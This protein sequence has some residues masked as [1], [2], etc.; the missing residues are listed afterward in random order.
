MSKEDDRMKESDGCSTVQNYMNGML[1]I[2]S[3]PYDLY[4]SIAA[5]DLN[6]Q[7]GKYLHKTKHSFLSTYIILVLLENSVHKKYFLLKLGSIML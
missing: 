6:F 1:P 3:G 5:R 2:E 4:C 7:N